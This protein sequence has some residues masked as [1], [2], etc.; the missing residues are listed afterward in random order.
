[1]N[2]RALGISGK[3]FVMSGK[4]RKKIRD[5]YQGVKG[6]WWWDYYIQMSQEPAICLN[7]IFYS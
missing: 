1:M 2:G 6:L 3:V 7:I 5:G 4:V